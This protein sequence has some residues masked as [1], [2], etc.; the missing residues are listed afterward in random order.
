[1]EQEQEFI[2]DM[3]KLSRSVRDANGNLETVVDH[4]IT[5]L[6]GFNER[7][8]YSYDRNEYFGGD[9]TKALKGDDLVAKLK[10][11]RWKHSKVEKGIDGF[12]PSPENI[13]AMRKVALEAA[14][15]SGKMPGKEDIFR[16]AMSCGPTHY[17]ENKRVRERA[18][19]IDERLFR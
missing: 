10:N 3:T 17:E 14:M 9:K 11:V 1:M 19:A 15:K 8:I 6:S 12:P 16:I 7:V 5:I 18:E 4:N 2:L 13:E